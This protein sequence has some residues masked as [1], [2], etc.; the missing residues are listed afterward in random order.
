MKKAS[1]LDLDQRY[2]QYLWP[3]SLKLLLALLAMGGSAVIDIA[4]P[5]PLKFIVDNVIGNKPFGNPI[6]QWAAGVLNYNPFFM[7]AFFV[8]VIV[9]LAVVGGILNF[10]YGYLQ[11]IIRERTTFALRSRVFAHLQSLS[12]EFHDQSR[13]G[14]LIARVTKDAANVMDALVHTAGEVVINFLNFV[15]IAV[16]MFFVNWRFSIIAL[17]YAPVL[18]MLFGLF[19]RKIKASAAAERTEDGQILN[20]THETISAILVVKAFGQE[21]EEQRR[22]EQYGTARLQAGLRSAFWESAFEP[23]ID[24]I[25]TA[26]MATVIWYGTTRI[27]NQTLTVGDLLIFLSYLGTFYNP[28]KRFSKLAGMLQTGIV[29]GERLTQLLDTQQVIADAPDAVEVDRVLGYVECKNVTF[30]Y[31]TSDLPSLSSISFAARAG[32]K[33]A[34]VGATGAGKTTLANVLMRF[35]DAS[36]GQVLLDGLDIRGISLKS[37][38]RQYALVPQ[39]PLLFAASIRSNIAYGK[40]EAN[41]KQIVKAAVAANAH[42]FIMR[43]PCGYDTILG[44]RGSRLSVGQRQRIAIARAFLQDAP[45]LVLDEPTAALDSASE[46]EV[47]KAVERLMENRTTFVIAHRLSTIRDADLILVLEGGRL[48]EYGSHEDLMALHGRY[49]EFVELQNGIGNELPLTVG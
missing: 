14:E 2:Y 12:L 5:W 1:I 40:P 45:I 37:L 24:L 47:M 21:E 44:E 29:S 27:L 16:V 17:V 9:V 46:R 28:L 26:G 15:G 19:R 34:I 13:S 43:L 8:G 39:E 11:G 10:T 25:K 22:F 33:V 38:R 23:I 35:Y 32:Q 31:K 30:S 3:H 49:A 41:L 18:Y 42:E 4:S 48:K 7:G 36:A 20:V 6:G